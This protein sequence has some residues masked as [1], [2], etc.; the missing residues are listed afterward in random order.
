MLAYFQNEAAEAQSKDK[1][2]KK[3]IGIIGK[4]IISPRK[5][6]LEGSLYDLVQPLNQGRMLL[7]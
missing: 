6:G 5:V 3:Y 1:I 4:E 2:F 7:V